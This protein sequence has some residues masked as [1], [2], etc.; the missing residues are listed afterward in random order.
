M[1]RNMRL[2]VLLSG[3]VLLVVCSSVP[4]RAQQ[5]S[6]FTLSSATRHGLARLAGRGPQRNGTGEA[7]IP[8]TTPQW[9]SSF[10]E[11]TDAFAGASSVYDPATNTMMVFAGIDWGMEGSDTNAA[12]LYAPANGNGNWT[13]LIAN[14]VAGSPPARVYH[15]A[16]YDSA[17][18]RMIVFGGEILTSSNPFNDVWVLSNANG[19]G[20]TAAW[21][22]LSP[23]GSPPAARAFHTAVYDAADNRMIIFGG[24]NLTQSFSDVWVL[25]NANGLGGTPVWTQLSPGGLLPTGVLASSAVYDPANNIMTV[26]GGANL[27]STA[28]SN[29]VWTLSHAN[30]LGG[31]PQWTNIVANGAAGSPAK[32]AYHTAVYDTASNRM[33]IF[34]GQ[35]FSGPSSLSGFNDVWVLTNAN[36]L[37][38]TPVW[39]RLRPSGLAPGTRF[40]HTAVYDA[41]NN[42]MMVF[43]GE[44]VDAVFY[45]VWVLSHAN[46]L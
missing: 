10:S 13:T 5:P 17:N 32:R 14:G 11:T 2:N 34:G 46:G 9:T 4:L 39:T 8:S 22:Q 41:I 40:L 7:Q 12:L 31:T 27:A 21:T 15:T 25:S 38:G 43:D 30:G 44:N 19:Q 24:G 29:G 3:L 18:N 37:G 1:K 42:L 16:V 36:G 26:F 6:A 20:G 45:A 23:S 33:I 35:A 28:Y